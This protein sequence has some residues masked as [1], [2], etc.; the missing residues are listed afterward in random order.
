MVVSYRSDAARQEINQPV[1]LRPNVK[2]REN[3]KGKSIHVRNIPNST[4]REF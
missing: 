4:G 1:L 3:E 2:I